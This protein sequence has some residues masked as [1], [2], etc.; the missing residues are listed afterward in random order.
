M[1][2]N[3]EIKA[4][5]RD[6]SA[7]KE[8]VEA[9][10]QQPATV[11]CQE[12]VFFKTTHGRLKLRL[13]N[14]RR[15]E[16]IY[17]ERPDQNGPKFCKYDVFE[18]DHPEQ[19]KKVLTAALGVRGEVRKT[20][21]FYLFGQTRLH[22]DRVESLG[23]FFELEVVLHTGQTEAEGQA[24]AYELMRKLGLN[25]EDLIDRAYIDLLEGKS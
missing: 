22:L 11:I 19:L 3:V 16:L 13:I 1:P 10:S 2:A 21:Y 15:A 4:R 6:F 25:Q 12:D 20:R 23:D 9:L 7:M 24:I 14:G 17:Y 8:K 18:T 5:L